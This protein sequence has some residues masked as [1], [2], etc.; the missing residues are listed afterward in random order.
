MAIEPASLTAALAAAS[1][2]TAILKTITGTIKTMGK[3]EVM[4]D[5]IELQ[6]AILEMQQ[7]QAEM[8]TENQS[9]KEELNKLKS[10]AD[11]SGKLKWTGR[12]YQLDGSGGFDGA[13]CGPCRDE[14]QKMIRVI[15]SG[16]AKHWRC[17]ICHTTVLK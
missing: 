6:S 11:L 3:A 15:E 1:H 14:R 13:Y 8:F 9:L 10:A 7:K 5:L 4:N 12:Y 16:D 2:A 17:T